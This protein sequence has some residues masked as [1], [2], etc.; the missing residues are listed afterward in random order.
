MF[1]RRLEIPALPSK[2][3]LMVPGNHD[4][5]LSLACAARASYDAPNKNI[6]LHDHE[7]NNQ[8]DLLVYSYRPYIDFAERICNTPWIEHA[9]KT[10]DSLSWV[11]SGFRHLGIMFYGINTARPASSMRSPNKHVDSNQLTKINTEMGSILKDNKNI[12]IIGLAHHSPIDGKK[13][14]DNPLDFDSF[15]RQSVGTS[16]FLYGDK[17]S[18]DI[19]YYSEDDYDLIN[20]CTSTLTKAEKSREPDTLRGFVLLEFM[21]QNGE[22]KELQTKVFSWNQKKLPK[23]NERYFIKQQNSYFF[24][25]KDLK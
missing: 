10:N 19:R 13:A 14:V 25:K 4:V 2:R 16:I 15:F 7:I 8:K 24:S 23:M 6:I 5:C 17:H 9:W 1:I 20:I 18:D 3:I 11:E 22:I 21:R 12:V